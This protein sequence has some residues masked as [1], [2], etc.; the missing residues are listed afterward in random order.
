MKLILSKMKKKKGVFC[1]WCE[2]FGQ[3][4]KAAKGK[5]QCIETGQKT[6]HQPKTSFMFA[7]FRITRNVLEGLIEKNLGMFKIDGKE[8]KGLV[9]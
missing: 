6:V 8:F 7:P 5:R 9:K 2:K 4:L 3:G 1:T